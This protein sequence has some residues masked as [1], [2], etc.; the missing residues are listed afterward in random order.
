MSGGDQEGIFEQRRDPQ[1]RMEDP[2]QQ[3]LQKQQ[4]GHRQHGKRICSGESR[5]KHE[6]EQDHVGCGGE[7]ESH[8]GGGG[9]SGKKSFSLIN[10][11]SKH[12]RFSE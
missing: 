3:Q 11:R 12:T 10:V 9:E 2:R 7:I 4:R 1:R 6:K 8:A 5:K